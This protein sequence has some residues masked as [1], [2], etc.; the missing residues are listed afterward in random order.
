MTENVEALLREE[1]IS[2]S[3]ADG[4]PRTW[5]IRHLQQPTMTNS[6]L[7]SGRISVVGTGLTAVKRWVPEELVRTD[8]PACTEL[9]REVRSGVRLQDRYPADAYPD[10]LIRLIGYNL[11]EAE[12]FVLVQS[13]RGQPFEDSGQLRPDERNAFEESLLRGLVFLAEAGVSHRDITASTVYWDGRTVQIRDFGHAR[14]AVR[15]DTEPVY[16]P[17]I[18]GPDVGAAGS[19]ILRAATGRGDLFGDDALAGRGEALRDL[20]DGVFLEPPNRRPTAATLLGRLN[21][22]V[23]VP[24]EDVS[25]WRRFE[26]GRTRFDEALRAKWPDRV[27][28]PAPP[29]ATP[30]TRRRRWLSF[31]LALSIMLAVAG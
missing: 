11:D 25:A 8:A 27:Q 14:L 16:L 13:V 3:S 19:L 22:T 12:P 10:E 21:V 26:E 31:G 29:P 4:E 1:N 30:T 20:L 17:T 24:A 18:G 9:E 23:D 28:V 2:F 5:R 15:S 7:L 6:G